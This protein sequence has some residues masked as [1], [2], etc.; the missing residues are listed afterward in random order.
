[1]LARIASFILKFRLTLLIIVGAFVI[2]MGILASKV[3]MTYSFPKLLPDTDSSMIDLDLF[4]SKFGE[5][6]TILVLGIDKSDIYRLANFKA[7]AGLGDSLKGLAGIKG[8]LS[9]ARLKE[10]TLNDSTG[11]FEFHDLKGS[12]PTTQDEL[13][14]LLLRAENIK[15]W[16]GVVFNSKTNAT[17]MLVTF[18]EKDLNSGRRIAIVENIKN[19]VK[20]FSDAT[21]INVHYSGL[22]Y[23]RTTMMAKI[24]H[25]MSFFLILSVIVTLLLLLFFFRSFPPVIFSILVVIAGMITSFGT[26]VLMGYKITILISLIPPLII[27][28]GVPNCILILNKYHTEIKNGLAKMEALHIAIQ[29]SAV[30]LFFANITTSIGFAVFCAIPSQI[31]FEFGLVTSLN[32]MI[33]FLFSLILVPVIF[34]YLSVPKPKHLEHL[35]AKRLRGILDKVALITV[36]HRKAIYFTV[37]ALVIICTF[38]FLRLKAFGYVVDDIPQKDAL[39]V[40][41]KY[42]EK[43]YGG[44]MPLEI[45]VDTKKPKG[46]KANSAR[47][48]YRI[49]RLQKMLTQYPELSKSI[50]VVDGLKYLYQTDKGGDA[51]YY[52]MP[53][54]TDLEGLI[55]KLK[56]EK[57]KHSELDN[58]MDSTFQYTRI[59]VYMADIGS[60]RVKKLVSELKPRIDSIFNYNQDENKWFPAE[61]K[62]DIRLTGSCITN[63]KGNEFLVSNLIE[64]VVLAIVLIAILMLTL[65]TSFGMILISIVPSLVALIITAGIM[66]FLGVPLKPSTI[67]IFSIAFGIS[68][69]GTLYFLTKYR[70]EIKKNNL[71]IGDA[72]R[73]TISE[74]GVS[75]V[76]TAFVLFF[77]FGMFALS[78]FGG[79]K[80][81]GLLL[82][83]T[84]ITAYCSNLV[85]LPAFLLS[86]EKRL[87]NKGFIANDSILGEALEEA[88]SDDEIKN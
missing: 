78:E 37:I 3:E 65:F 54:V 27:V 22:P 28:I 2:W 13:N 31:F 29:R 5:D 26:V 8:V 20:K 71:S 57:G 68:S 15:I 39:I 63:L 47:A 23:I 87:T 19:E 62:I 30:S 58:L 64:S 36:N 72:V 7:W 70:H 83:F 11:K 76:Y 17:R 56:T 9:I 42:F 79:T 34:S 35:E 84:L 6:G 25:E 66:G 67:L 88:E 59:S 77:G 33:T 52:K 32:V 24:R 41:L 43:N 51:K 16:E 49:N 50:S 85:L 45:I 14:D 18:Y 81:L 53:T 21:G 10:L 55:D 75:M 48:V 74:T 60:I 82:S 61:E 4:R 73:L 69:D 80:A 46:L 86:M 40:D 1:M 12:N 38:G 44:V